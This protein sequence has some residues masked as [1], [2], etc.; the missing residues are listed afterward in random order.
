VSITLPTEDRE[1][2]HIYL[3]LSKLM[4]RPQTHI[5]PRRLAWRPILVE[6]PPGKPQLP[7]VPDSPPPVSTGPGYPEFTLN[8]PLDHMPPELRA[9]PNNT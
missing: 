3:G 8:N 6:H 4:Q 1:R 7:V 5:G 2:S 9:L